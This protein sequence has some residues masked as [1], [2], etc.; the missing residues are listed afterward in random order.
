MIGVVHHPVGIHSVEMVQQVR[1]EQ[2]THTH[3]VDEHILG[4]PNVEETNID[5]KANETIRPLNLVRAHTLSQEELPAILE[6]ECLTSGIQLRQSLQ[7]VC[8]PA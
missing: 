5:A 8:V 6:A 3:R 2:R 1:Q 4:V 7:K